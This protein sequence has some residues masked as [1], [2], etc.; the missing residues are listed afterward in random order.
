MWN[1]AKWKKAL[2]IAL[3]YFGIILPTQW[4]DSLAAW[5]NAMQGAFAAAQAP[6]GDA[7]GDSG[8]APAAQPEAPEC[9]TCAG[10]E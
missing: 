3:A 9:T 8:E 5:F 10:P 1:T 2:I 6:D 7:A 4:E